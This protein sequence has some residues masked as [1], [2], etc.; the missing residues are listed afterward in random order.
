MRGLGRRVF[1]GI[2]G[3]GMSLFLCIF[4]YGILCI[5]LYIVLYRIRHLFLGHSMGGIFIFV[6]PEPESEDPDTLVEKMS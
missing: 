3:V 5:V 4:L 2:G 6:C 1:V